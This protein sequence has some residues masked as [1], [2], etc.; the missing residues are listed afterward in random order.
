[1]QKYIAGVDI[2]GTKTAVLL[3]KDIDEE[4]PASELFVDRRQFSTPVGE[5]AKNGPNEIVRQLNRLLSDT[6]VS[7]NQLSSIGVSCGSPLDSKTGRILSPPN[8]FGWDDVP[9]TD[10]LER[11]FGVTARL[12]NDADACALAEWMYGAGR[13]SE[14]MIFLTMGTGFG[15]GLVLGGRLYTGASGSAGEIGHLRLTSG[16]PVGYGKR[17]SVE[18]YCSGGGIAQVA[19]TKALEMLQTGKAVSFCASLAA[20]DSITAQSVAVAA[21]DGNSDA[22][23]VYRE[24]GEY[25]GSAL[26]LIIDLLNP[27]RIVIGSIFARSENLLRKSMQEVIDRETLTSANRVCTVVPARLGERIGDYATICAARYKG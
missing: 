6:G 24:V 3:A 15:A 1:M 12:Q 13:G 9:I 2:G 16:G 10:I 4:I 17:G 8:L 27:Q 23:D 18:G 7:K 20:L 19:R 5:Q 25:L 14:H 11:E 22:L 21:N 26:S